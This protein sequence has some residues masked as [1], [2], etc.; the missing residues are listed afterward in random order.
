MGVR[1][2]FRLLGR[3]GSNR[4]SLRVADFRHQQGVY[5]LYDDYGPSYVG[6]TRNQGMGKRLKDHKTDHLKGRWDRFSW[7]GFRPLL[8]ASATSGVL[9]LGDPQTDVS[10]DTST[11]IGDL[12]ALLIRAMGP[13]RNRQH[14]AFDCAE[15]WTQIAYDDGDHY[16]GRA[17]Q[18]RRVTG[19]AAIV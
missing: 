13:K 12:E 4:G 9:G 15:R 6:L 8:P 18:P 1:D 19:V 5:I 16:L 3:I 2:S 10:G 17:V 7:F 14:M 11:T